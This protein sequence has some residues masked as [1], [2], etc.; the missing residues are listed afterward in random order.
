MH[1]RN[2]NDPSQCDLLL[3]VL[4]GQ[5]EVRGINVARAFEG[6][7]EL[8]KWVKACR[9]GERPNDGYYVTLWRILFRYPEIL[10]WETLWN[11]SVHETYEAIYKQTKS[12]RPEAKVGWHVWHASELQ[13]VVP[14][15]DR[16][17]QDRRL[18]RLHEDHRL[19]QSRRHAHGNLHYKHQQDDLRRYAHRR[20]SAIRI[21]DH[22]S[23]ESAD[24]PNFH[25]P[26]FLRITSIVKPTVRSKT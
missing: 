25:T 13:P 9:G 5:G 8:G 14:R 4:P 19:Q 20:G 22:E 15:A 11:D 3:R 12:I 16:F 21:S 2:G 18:L 10:A 26:A 24:T 6:F 23:C 1:T 17:D 7:H